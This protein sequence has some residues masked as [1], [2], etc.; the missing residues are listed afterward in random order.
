MQDSELV[1]KKTHKRKTSLKELENSFS[2]QAKIREEDDI[3]SY[4]QSD[5]LSL[6]NRSQEN[7]LRNQNFEF[8]KEETP[9]TTARLISII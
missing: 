9:E 2:M 5:C 1:V 3:D 7:R 6:Q 4:N 8:N